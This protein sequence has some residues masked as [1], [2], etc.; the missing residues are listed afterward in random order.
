VTRRELIALLGTTAAVALPFA[1]RAQQSSM[2]VIGMLAVA[3]APR[4]HGPSRRVRNSPSRTCLGSVCY[5]L[6]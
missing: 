5:G 4:R 1:A 2:P 6:A 3:S